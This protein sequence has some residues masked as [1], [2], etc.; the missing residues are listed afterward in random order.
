[1]DL[2]AIKHI[3]R[4]CKVN[5]VEKYKDTDVYLQFYPKTPRAR[6]PNKGSKQ[7]QDDIKDQIDE[8]L[9]ITDPARWEEQQIDEG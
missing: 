8:D 3:I 2:N 7:Q 6:G 5:G 4:L 9:I 1:M